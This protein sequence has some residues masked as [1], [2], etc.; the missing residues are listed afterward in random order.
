MVYALA[1]SY[2]SE[3]FCLLELQVS[4]N[5]ARD[6]LPDH[7]LRRITEHTNGSL[8]P[9]FDHP[10]Q[11]FADNGIVGRIDNARESQAACLVLLASCNVARRSDPFS[12]FAFGAEQRNS[13]R[14]GPTHR[15]VRPQHAMFK[16]EHVLA[17]N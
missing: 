1:R 12:H 16:L 11:I 7:F 4:R 3:Y 17:A 15:T 2:P 10:V 14:K 6:G 9:G 13:P 8:I 5:E